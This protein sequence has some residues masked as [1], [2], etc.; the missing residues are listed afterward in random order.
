MGLFTPFLLILHNR[1]AESKVG[2]R[3]IKKFFSHTDEK[4]RRPEGQRF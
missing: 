1:A 2:S 3:E 4:K